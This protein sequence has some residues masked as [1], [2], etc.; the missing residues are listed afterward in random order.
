MQSRT[1]EA[2]PAATFLG[3]PLA[4]F[5]LLRLPRLRARRLL[6]LRPLPRV[7]PL[8]AR[9]VE[10]GGGPLQVECWTGIMGS[11]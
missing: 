1:R 9:E 11:E 6:C 2:A 3:R 10:G 7:P 4:A 5:P 8:E